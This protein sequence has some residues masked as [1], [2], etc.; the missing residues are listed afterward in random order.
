M[1]SLQLKQYEWNYLATLLQQGYTIEQAL[2]Y[3]KEDYDI[4]A[5]LE[6]GKDIKT[7]LIGNQTSRF[8]RHFA[9]FLAITSLPQAIIC[10]QRMDTFEKNIKKKLMKETSYPILIFVC[11]FLTLYFFSTFILP[12]M[13]ENFDMGKENAFLTI[14]VSFLQALA[15]G[16]FLMV[17]LSLCIFA[18]ALHKPYCKQYLLK[19][20]SKVTSLFA[21]IC[22]YTLSGYLY[23]LHH[24]G[25][26]TL[27]AITF[28][29]QLPKDTMLA[30]LIKE[31]E[32]ALQVGV[33][34]VTV[35]KQQAFLNDSFKQCFQIGTYSG[36]LECMLQTFMIRQEEAWFRKIKAISIGIQIVA[37]VFVAFM[38]VLV[39][40]IMLVPLQLLDTM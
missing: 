1:N 32:Q 16:L 8:H 37:Y 24:Q 9:F 22:S 11:A 4:Q 39:Y 13:M 19:K 20:G 14:G 10:A 31:I 2:S 15:E 28:L 25:T 33:D 26:S 30:T 12:Q 38:V 21:D 5:E 36:D 7:I 3:V 34:I 27:H 23:E 35:M 17:M 40:Q 6:Q 18:I 29:N